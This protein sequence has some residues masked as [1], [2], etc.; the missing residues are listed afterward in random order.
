M[1]RC[2]A[3]DST[4]RPSFKEI[5]DFVDNQ[6]NAAEDVTEEEFD[7][8]LGI[9]YPEQQQQKQHHGGSHG[10]LED[11]SKTAIPVLTLNF[12]STETTL[13]ELYD[14]SMGLNDPMSS[15]NF[16]IALCQFGDLPGAYGVVSELLTNATPD[17]GEKVW[18]TV[19]FVRGAL[20][21][22]LGD[23]YAAAKDFSQAVTLMQALSL[24]TIA[25]PPREHRARGPLQELLPPGRVRL[26][27][28]VRRGERLL[29]PHDHRVDPR[30]GAHPHLRRDGEDLH[31]GPRQ[32]ELAARE[33]L[34][35]PRPDLLLPQRLRQRQVRAGGP[36]PPGPRLLRLRALPLVPVELQADIH[37][38]KAKTL[39]RL[40]RYAEASAALEESL[41]I[42]PS[43]SIPDL[44]SPRDLMAQPEV[45]AGIVCGSKSEHDFQK[46]S[47]FSISMVCCNFCGRIQLFQRTI[48]RCARCGYTVHAQCLPMLKFMQCYG[49]KK[50][51][52]EDEHPIQ[53]V[54]KQSGAACKGVCLRLPSPDT[55]TSR[56][57]DS[58]DDEAEQARRGE[59]RGEAQEHQQHAQARFHGGDL[60]GKGPEQQG[61]PERRKGE[62]RGHARPRHA[63]GDTVL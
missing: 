9:L 37:I 16:T 39:A 13:Q 55:G 43:Q 10:D 57:Y 5:Y 15:L 59:E 18:A 11:K 42:D 20:N 62:V 41:K 23:F 2:W 60:R 34:L 3:A 33:R 26:G 30:R 61:V 6:Y 49:E 24:P 19:F 48:Y 45:P 44:K 46:I 47:V 32:E 53:K 40:N 54:I 50:E 21:T 1:L 52:E 17:P 8:I 27:R 56:H 38:M 31:A 29:L 14:Q 51:E 7:E 4:E 36:P 35:Q 12:T 25:I 22:R 63:P 58:D 28:G